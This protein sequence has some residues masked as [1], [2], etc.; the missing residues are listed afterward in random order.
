ML[1]AQGLRWMEQSLA[2]RLSDVMIA[3]LTLSLVVQRFTH[4]QQFMP[5]A[6][7]FG[8]F[9]FPL[10]LRLSL[11]VQIHV[12]VCDHSM[13]CATTDATTGGMPPNLLNGSP[14]SP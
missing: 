6:V 2:M 14:H 12:S 1:N 9:V 4:L 13:W 8:C 11:L 7:A 3:P 10:H 5:S